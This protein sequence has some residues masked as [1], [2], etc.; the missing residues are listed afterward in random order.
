MDPIHL[1][2]VTYDCGSGLATVVQVDDLAKAIAGYEN[3]RREKHEIGRNEIE[4]LL[5]GADDLL[6]LEKL[7]PMCFSTSTSVQDIAAA[8]ERPTAA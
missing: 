6:T 4:L 2:L 1:Y 7:H 3:L 5:V 8:F